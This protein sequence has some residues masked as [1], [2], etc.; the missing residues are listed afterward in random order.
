MRSLTDGES[1]PGVH[2]DA[3]AKNLIV[4]DQSVARIATAIEHIFFGCLDW[5]ANNPFEF[6]AFLAFMAFAAFLRYLEKVQRQRMDIDFR[7][8][9]SKSTSEPT[10]LP[11]GIPPEI[12]EL[13]HR[14]NEN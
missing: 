5:A 2:L 3:Q 14:Q 6:Y 13:E 11:T 9:R 4:S 12:R 7:R 8:T 1:L 10:P